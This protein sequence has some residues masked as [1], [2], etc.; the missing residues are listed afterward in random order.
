MRKNLVELV[1]ALVL[2]IMASSAMADPTCITSCRMGAQMNLP[3]CEW[4]DRSKQ[5][6]GTIVAVPGL[7]LYAMCWDQFAKHLAT[8][9]YHVF[10]LDLRG[11]G[12][13]R[14]EGAKFNGNDKIE[15]GQSEQDLLDLVT[16]LRQAHP[17]QPLFCL[18][19]SLGSNMILDLV[20][21]HPDL[22]DGAI[23]AS[24]CY[25][26][27]VHPKPIKWAGEIARQMV[28]PNKPINLEPYAAPYLTNDQALAKAC[29]N[30]PMIYRKMTPAELVKID[31]LNDR[32]F[33]V[34]KKLPASYPIFIIAGTQD[35]MFKSME[36]PKAVH[37]FGSHSVTVTLLPGKGHLL[38]E[39]QR[40]NHQIAALVDGWL[41]HHKASG[42]VA[43]A[44][45]P[46]SNKN[47]QKQ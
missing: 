8:Q 33:A 1:A 26:N 42:T 23:L 36:L 35:A 3:I 25:K 2:S 12:R 19:E 38:L 40:V 11:F 27:R 10:S 31:I 20:S 45:V 32:A 17:T 5:R 46:P 44:P 15:I 47:S 30:D 7:T 24:P 14:T 28:R 43:N 4:V 34:A 41:N 9:G 22:S 18:G 21:E 13:W 39:H 16:D 29:D 37:K 6:K